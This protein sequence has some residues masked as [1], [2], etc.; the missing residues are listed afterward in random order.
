MYNYS[1]LEVSSKVNW[2]IV[3]KTIV[4]LADSV[5]G[6]KRKK[7]YV[8]WTTEEKDAVFQHLGKFI[9]EK[10]RLPGKADCTRCIEKSKGV[11]ARRD[12]SAV[13]YCVMNII[14]RADSLKDKN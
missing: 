9:K 4:F 10:N 2:F 1:K 7:G 11:L 6:K 13:K 3:P 5:P 14:K 8:P 12:W